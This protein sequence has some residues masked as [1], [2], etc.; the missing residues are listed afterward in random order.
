MAIG[1]WTGLLRLGF[2]LPV[3]ST[4][5][6]PSH[7]AFMIAGFL[8]TVI[9]LER[10]VALGRGWGYAAP[11]FSAAGALALILGASFTA[12]LAF[13]VAGAVLFVATV[14]LTLRR[15]DMSTFTLALAV[16]CW[17]IGTVLWLQ[18]RAMPAVAG[19]WLGFL[20]L[21]IAA[22]RLELS[23]IVG[24]SRFAR[25]IFLIAAAMPLIGAARGEL[26][27]LTAPFI[28]VGLI[29]LGIWLLQHDIARRIV[30]QTGQPRFTAYSVIAG[31]GW[32]TAAG[33]LLLFA[34]PAGGGFIYD[35]AV[36]A[37]AIGFIFS[38]IFG[39]APII[40]PAI[41]GARIGF[42]RAVYGALALLHGSV[43]IRVV[44]DLF[45]WPDLRAASAVLTIAALV[46]YALSLVAGSRRRPA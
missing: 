42:H 38:M 35:A 3:A 12:G 1:L 21:T 19:W 28:A 46:G 39:H 13:I 23:R 6:A 5:A 32:L 9:S 31:E 20:I 10:A 7:S 36:H 43:I 41:T 37:I 44:A 4:I 14:S 29:G 27:G 15:L 24:V 40:L 22:E 18:G 34:S 45:A 33:L 26:A 11:A 2:A 8:G 16:A 25:L 30:S 17:I